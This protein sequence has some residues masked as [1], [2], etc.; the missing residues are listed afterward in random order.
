MAAQTSDWQHT[1]AVV[2]EFCKKNGLPMPTEEEPLRIQSKKAQ[3]VMSVCNKQAIVVDKTTF[4]CI[5]HWFLFIEM[6]H[7]NA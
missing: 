1:V 5:N 2:A 3:M 6:E 7:F 4:D